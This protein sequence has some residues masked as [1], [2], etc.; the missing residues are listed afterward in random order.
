VGGVTIDAILGRL[1]HERSYRSR[2]LQG[3]PLP[4]ATPEELAALG[5]VD[6]T[7]LTELA[8]RVAHD[9]MG[10]SHCGSGSLPNLFP[11]TIE[12]FRRAHP[13]GG[14]LL[15]LAYSF[16]D[17]REFGDYREHP[18]SGLG[19]TLEE[20][21]FRY[22]ESTGIG[23]AVVREREFLAAVMKL[24]CVSPR[25]A[26][27]VPG[28]VRRTDHGY[29]CVSSR[30]TPAL[31]ACVKG[32]FVAGAL[33]PFLADLLAPG[34]NFLVTAERHGVSRFVLEESVRQLSALGILTTHGSHAIQKAATR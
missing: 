2:F 33:T 19:T 16:M 24:L 23:D 20:A 26:A 5:A 10:R 17:S 6:P 11:R 22:C 21:F 25:V 18:F 14:E 7:T 32:H 28:C 30:G 34:V 9:V 1:I 27:R 12:S 29:Y 15:E 31:Y 13:G 8:E 4:D 3:A